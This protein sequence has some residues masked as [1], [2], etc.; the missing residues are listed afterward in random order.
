MTSDHTDPSVPDINS[1]LKML[2]ALQ[3]CSDTQFFRLTPLSLM[4]LQ[5]LHSLP[6]GLSWDGKTG[7]GGGGGETPAY[8]KIPIF[9]RSFFIY[10]PAQCDVLAIVVR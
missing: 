7:W 1:A 4:A 9:S 10:V 3:V 6:A 8:W 2:Y 5:F